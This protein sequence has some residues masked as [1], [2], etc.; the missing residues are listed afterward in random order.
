MRASARE[1]TILVCCFTAGAYL[2]LFNLGQ[3]PLWDDEAQTAILARNLVETGKLTGW[4]GRNLYIYRDGKVLDRQL[5]PINPP[6]DVL[7]TALSLRV[8]GVSTWSARLPFALTGLAAL[9]AF[10]LVLMA[11]LPDRRKL[12][13]WAFGLLALSTVFSLYTRQCRYYAPA[14]LF[15]LLTWWGYRLALASPGAVSAVVLGGSAILLF[16]SHYLIAIVFL[17][18]LWTL[19]LG[20]EARAVQRKQWLAL[21]AG[22]GIFLLVALPYAVSRRIWLRPDMPDYETAWLM[23]RA[24]LLC[25]HVRDAG[26]A[27][28]APWLALMLAGG[29]LVGTKVEPRVRTVVGRWLTLSVAI[30]LLTALLSP[31]PIASQSIAD[32][33]YTVTSLPF[34]AG[35]L[36][37][38]CWRLSLNRDWR[39]YA[40][41]LVGLLLVATNLLTVVPGNWGPRWLLPALVKQLHS[42]Y[43]TAY[44]EACDY[45]AENASPDEIVHAYPSEANG[46][47]H[48]YLG[49]RLL[50]GA[51]IRVPGHLP[52]DL[53]DSLAPHTHA[54]NCF[55]HWFV[56]FGHHIEVEDAL[57]FFSRRHQIEG[58]WRTYP[59]QLAARLEVTAKDETRPELYWHRFGP[60]RDFD[61]RTEAVYIFRRQSPRTA[62]G[63]P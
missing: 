12:R 31:Q 40:G 57:V 6:L 9:G 50:I 38:A 61:K 11:E 4:D 44:G 33:R 2:S 43:P 21:L 39:R 42:P 20:W 30:T 59:Y 47:L 17:L 45:L 29:L 48:F 3:T 63:T 16:L 13:L 24:T 14:M 15:A 26:A 52:P 51:T 8:F 56:A 37:F 22:G 60:Q 41:R 34:F 27:G 28:I 18:S 1:T 25:W 62:V 36:G 53:V 32:T 35:V 10:W 19:F 49:D 7:A 55:P 58:D 5:R 23:R 46:P 54:T